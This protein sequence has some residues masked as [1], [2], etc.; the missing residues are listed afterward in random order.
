MGGKK[1]PMAKA[2]IRE[3]KIRKAEVRLRKRE[4]KY[5]GL[6]THW[7]LLGYQVKLTAGSCGNV[8]G[9]AFLG[10]FFE[11]DE[12]RI[13]HPLIV[14]SFAGLILHLKSLRLCAWFHI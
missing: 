3:C 12:G 10:K 9:T 1:E 4:N 8:I 6:K 14:V 11:E 2:A 13:I 7:P 5:Q